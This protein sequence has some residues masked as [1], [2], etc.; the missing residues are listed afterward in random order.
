LF[1][2]V[3]AE[4]GVNAGEQF[5]QAEWLEQIIIRPAVE[6]FHA[7]VDLALGGEH[8]HRHGAA[9]FA[10]LAAD[11][12]AIEAG[13]HHIEQDEVEGFRAG[14][15]KAGHSIGGGADA[16]ALGGE[17]LHQ[18][19]RFG[20]YG[21]EIAFLDHR[22]TRGGDFKAQILA[23]THRQALHHFMVAA[24]SCGLLAIDGQKQIGPRRKVFSSHAERL[25]AYRRVDEM[26]PLAIGGQP[27]GFVAVADPLSRRIDLRVTFQQGA[28]LLAMLPVFRRFPDLREHQR[29]QHRGRIGGR[30]IHQ[31]SSIRRIA[32]GFKH[33]EA[34]QN[35]PRQSCGR[36]PGLRIVPQFPQGNGIIP[37]QYR[38]RCGRRARQR[39]IGKQRGRFHRRRQFPRHGFLRITPRHFRLLPRG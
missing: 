14:E 27:P 1:A 39:R 35:P 19:E 33:T 24:V 34:R 2:L 25:H 11:G 5:F 36:N 29:R 21:G 15:F 17:R 8:E 16:V 22:R 31:N 6:A 10:E 18:T 38:I 20:D 3:A 26:K 32:S 4:Q 37:I 13:H 12:E 30:Q 28:R 23:E 7:V 9:A